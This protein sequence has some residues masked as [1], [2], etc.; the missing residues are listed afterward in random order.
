MRHMMT[1]ED[2]KTS[3]KKINGFGD[4]MDAE[5]DV[6]LEES[7]IEQQIRERAERLKRSQIKEQ[8]HVRRRDRR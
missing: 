5:T 7:V 3:L 8:S 1:E 2:L 6:D 4:T